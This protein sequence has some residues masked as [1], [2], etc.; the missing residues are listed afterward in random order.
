[1]A[2]LELD[3]LGA[4]PVKYDRIVAKTIAQL[5]AFVPEHGNLVPAY[6]EED[7]LMYRW[8][9]STWEIG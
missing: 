1:M 2:V 8:N 9:G 4:S 3:G 6:C 5:Q 7:G